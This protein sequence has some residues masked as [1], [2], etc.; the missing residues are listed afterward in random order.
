MGMSKF[1]VLNVVLAVVLLIL[2]I[3]TLFCMKQDGK[4]EAS[5]SGSGKSAI[6]II[7]KRTSVRDYTEKKVTR[8]VGNSCSCRYGCSNG[9]E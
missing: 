2:I 8:S 4:T 6:E 1:K 7:H 5:A 3:L 9:Y